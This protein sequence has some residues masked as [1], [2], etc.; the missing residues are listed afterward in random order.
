MPSPTTTC[1]YCNSP[2]AELTPGPRP[3]CPRCGEPLPAALS[4]PPADVEASPPIPGRGDVLGATGRS[5]RAVAGILLGVMAVFAILGL[6]YALWT[7][8]FREKNH[9]PSDDG[10]LATPVN[11]VALPGLDRKSTRLNSS[12]LGISY[13]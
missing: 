8:G 7:Q 9:P 3:L 11:P 2:L 13:A 1:P 12:H 5:N 10:A 4:A 6:G